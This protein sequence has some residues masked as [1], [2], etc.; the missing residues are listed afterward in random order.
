MASKEYR[1]ISCKSCPG[2]FSQRRAGRSQTNGWHVGVCGDRAPADD[3]QCCKDLQLPRP[4]SIL[5]QWT[6]NIYHVQ[7]VRR[8]HQV[9]SQRKF[10]PAAQPFVHAQT[11]TPRP[12][13]SDFN[14]MTRSKHSNR[15]PRLSCRP[16]YPRRQGHT[17]PTHRQRHDRRQCVADKASINSG[18]SRGRRR[19]RGREAK[20]RCQR[21]EGEAARAVSTSGRRGR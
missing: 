16:L 21:L 17:R 1:V 11:H 10:V 20:R 2:G 8:V 18:G 4:L 14:P 6:N 7:C 5:N 19:G 12:A 9:P 13:C 3:R 15:F